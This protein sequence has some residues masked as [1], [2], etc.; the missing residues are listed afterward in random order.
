[1]I[2]AADAHAAIL[3]NHHGLFAADPLAL[4]WTSVYHDDRAMVMIP[5]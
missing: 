3:P 4:H 2:L 5:P 1:M